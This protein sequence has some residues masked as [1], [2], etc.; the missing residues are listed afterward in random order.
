MTPTDPHPA[1]ARLE[2]GGSQAGRM[3]RAAI[4]LPRPGR[5]SGCCGRSAGIAV[6]PP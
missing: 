4:W 1:P 2:P 3:V 5:R 6:L